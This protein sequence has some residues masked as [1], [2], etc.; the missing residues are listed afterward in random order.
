MLRNFPKYL[1][2][3]MEWPSCNPF[4][5]E[6]NTE[7]LKMNSFTFQDDNRENLYMTL[8]IDIYKFL[9]FFFDDTL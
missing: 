1:D 4:L 9:T 6:N 2:N 7:L 3:V 5:L 8:G